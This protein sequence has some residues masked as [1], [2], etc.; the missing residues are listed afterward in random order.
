M[1]ALL[2]FGD[3]WPTVNPTALAYAWPQISANAFGLSWSNFAVA[4]H[5]VPDAANVIYTLNPSAGDVSC[6]EVGNNDESYYGSDSGKQALFRSGLDALAAWLALPTKKYANG[7]GSFTGSWATTGVYGLGKYST[8]VGS[9][10]SFS[11]SGT[12]VYVGLIQQAGIHSTYSIWID[13]VSQGVFSANADGLTTSNGVTYGP[14]LH[15]FSG[16]SAG[17]HTVMVKV[18]TIPNPASDKVY[19]DWCAG[20]AQ[21][22]F[23]ELWLMNLSRYTAAGYAN[24]LGGH[25][26]DANVAAYNVEIASCAAA[27]VSDGLNVNVCD[28]Y[29][30]TNLATDMDAGGAHWNNRGHA[31]GAC[32]FISTRP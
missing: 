1:S 13:G 25:G 2:T 26:S 16:L 19:V 6:L 5:M 14:K 8:S 17:S 22:A 15:R 20:N 12:A 18:E 32:K 24:S 23:N 27:L 31:R 29:S 30:V 4:G 3:S 9:T 11:V 10:C 7:A 21:A 28:F